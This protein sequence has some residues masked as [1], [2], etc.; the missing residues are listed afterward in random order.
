MQNEE[1]LPL[2]SLVYLKRG[3]IKMLIIGRSNLITPENKKSILF[4]YS[5]VPYPVGY[6]GEQKTYYFNQEDID[7]VEF[8]GFSDSEDTQFIKT[9]KEWQVE[10][11]KDYIRKDV[12]DLL[13]E[14][15]N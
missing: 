4:D 11:S 13:S 12:D 14:E 9:I 3:T 2:G 7:K 8:K 1:I 10:N 6:L 15:N 5:A